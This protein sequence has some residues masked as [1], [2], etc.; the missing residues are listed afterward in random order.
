MNSKYVSIIY[1][2]LVYMYLKIQLN[3]KTKLKWG[4]LKITNKNQRSKNVQNNQNILKIIAVTC[5]R[6][7]PL[8]T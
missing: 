5:T 4:E 2:I 8:W 3:V 1:K 7:T 6:I